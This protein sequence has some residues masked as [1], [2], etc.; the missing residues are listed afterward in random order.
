MNSRLWKVWHKT[1]AF[2]WNVLLLCLA[3]T[4]VNTLTYLIMEFTNMSDYNRGH[5]E[6]FTLG[7]NLLVWLEFLYRFVKTFKS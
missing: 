3:L 1:T 7:I 6:L 5:F 4:G 2:S